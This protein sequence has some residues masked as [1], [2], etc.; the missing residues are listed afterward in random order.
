M[1]ITQN[2]RNHKIEEIYELILDETGIEKLQLN[3][4][5]FHEGVAGDDFHEL[6]DQYQK[7]FKVNMNAYSWYFHTDEEGFNFPGGLFFKPPYERVTRIAITPELLLKFANSGTWELDYPEHQ[8]P[9]KRY[10]LQVN[11]VFSVTFFLIV[12]ILLIYKLLY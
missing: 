2:T 6:I 3:T 5:I 9:S 4:D 10:D 12:A 1:S 8:L 7:Q 11:T